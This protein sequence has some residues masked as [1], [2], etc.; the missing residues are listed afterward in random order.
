M[1]KQSPVSTG[2]CLGPKT[3]QPE[4]QKQQYQLLK[5][6]GKI[7]RC[8]GCQCEFDKGDSNLYILGKRECD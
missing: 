6:H 2:K 3:P 8:N 5:R 1:E 7:S 4:P